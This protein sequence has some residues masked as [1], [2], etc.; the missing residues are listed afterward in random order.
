MTW[1]MLSMRKMQLKSEISDLQYEDV[2]ISNQIQD[3]S[4]YANNIADGTITYSEMASC[5]SSLFGTQLD[6]MTNCASAA[7]ES[8]TSKTNA[9][10]Q[11]LA[12]TNSETGNQYGYAMGTTDSTSYDTT[13]IFNE[14]YKEEMEQYAEEMQEVI[15]DYEEELEQRR[16]QVET[17]LEAKEAE[18]QT[19]DDRISQNIQDQAISL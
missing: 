10:I 12:Q 2:Q 5:P 11:Q 14:I 1:I 3:L 18:L 8:A 17:Q 6:F 9:Y 16:T 13:T 15:N 7:Y 19:Y 4:E